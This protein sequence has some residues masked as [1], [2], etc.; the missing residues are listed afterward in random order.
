MARTTLH[1]SGAASA[2]VLS[3]ADVW[4]QFAERLPTGASVRVRTSSGERFTGWLLAVDGEGIAVNPRT[5]VPEPMRRV[6]F[7]GIASIET[8]SNKGASLA[9]AAAVGAGV[10]AGVFVGLLMLALSGWD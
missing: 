3:Q 9:K 10:G 2:Q 1:P 5:R 4:R 8:V 7:D 6:P